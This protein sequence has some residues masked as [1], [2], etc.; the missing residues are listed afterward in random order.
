[1]K[2]LA[3]YLLVIAIIPLG[4]AAFWEYRVNAAIAT[5]AEFAPRTAARLVVPSGTRIRAVLKDGITES[6]EPGEHV[7]AFVS[8]AVMVHNR[9]AIPIGARLNG[10]VQQITKT[11]KDAIVWLRFISLVIDR[12]QFSIQAEPVVTNLPLETDIEILGNALDTVTE[13]G[14]G[15]AIGA[16]AQTEEAISAGLAAGAL[17]GASGLDKHDVQITVVL[18]Q[19]IELVV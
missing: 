19:P 8:D 4:I 5:A 9:L 18:T 14:V 13:A 6:T 11:D 3:L 7:V 16:A 17:R 10:Q 2:R 1:M 12:R 15:V